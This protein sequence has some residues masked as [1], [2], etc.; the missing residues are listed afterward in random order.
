MRFPP[1]GRRKNWFFSVSKLKR[2]VEITQL[3]AG[4]LGCAEL[5]LPAPT[6]MP[7]RIAR[8]AKAPTIHLIGISIDLFTTIL[9]GCEALIL[10]AS[11]RLRIHG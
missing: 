8:S 9:R 1:A 5:N 3:A 4:A 11:L 10:A 7:N 6:T 2:S